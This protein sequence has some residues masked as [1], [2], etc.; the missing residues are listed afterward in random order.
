MA[1]SAGDVVL[2]PFPFRDQ[3]GE[4]ARP[5][6]VVSAQA[7]NQQG[8]LIV[9]AITSHPPRGGMDYALLD[10]SAANLQLPSTTRMLLATVAE[11]RILLH[12]GQ[13]SS[14]D[15]SEVQDRIRQVFTWP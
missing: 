10:W 7:Y 13:L 5:A 1:F 12:I 4:R 15:W 11:T 3:P 9:A 6:I 2:V 14:R 8:D